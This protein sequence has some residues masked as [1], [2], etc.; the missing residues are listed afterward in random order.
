MKKILVMTLFLVFSL[1][2]GF[3]ADV[4]DEYSKDIQIQQSRV[5][6]KNAV[7][8]FVYSIYFMFDK[9]VPVDGFLKN[10]VEKGLNMQFPGSP[11]KSYD[12]FKKWYAD[13]G[14]NTKTQRHTVKSVE[15]SYGPDKT[16]LVHVIVL[17]EAVDSK[18]TFIQFLA[19]QNWTV[20]EVDGSLK[21]RDYIVKAAQ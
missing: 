12:D 1:T 14:T 18:G 16:F 13:V 5:F 15:V 17:W 11:L 7:L 19:D 6:N 10:L 8:S 3:A 21:I 9:H 4:S 2:C 20:V